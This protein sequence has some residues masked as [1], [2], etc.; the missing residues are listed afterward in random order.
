MI[1]DLRNW[2]KKYLNSG[3]ERT[4]KAK[5]NIFGLFA[6][7]GISILISMLIVPLTINYISPFKYGIW[8]TLSSLITWLGFFDIGLGNGLKNKFT[9]TIALGN[10]KLARTYVSTTYAILALIILFVLT[11]ALVVCFQVNWSKILNAPPEINSELRQVSIII[12][13]NFC[14]QLVLKIVNTLLTAIQKPALA[15]VF[16]TIS[17]IIVA[18]IIYLLIRFTDGSLFYLSLAISVTP[19]II[20]FLGS[21]WVFSH[22]LKDYRPS[23]QYVKFK[24]GK[25][26]LSLGVGFFL[27]QVVSIVCYSTNNIIITQ[28]LG[29][30]EVTVYNI[31]YKYFMVINMVFMIILIPFWSAFTE[32]STL[33]DIEWMK[34]MTKKLRIIFFLISIAGILMI[35]ASPV[36][37]KLWI[38]PSV[39]IPVVVSVLMC[40]YHLTNTWGTLHSQLM[41]GIGKIRMQLIGSIISG[42]INIPLT[43]FL[44]KWM[45]LPGILV[46]NIIV[47]SIFGLWVGPVQLNKIFNKRA[48]GIW[49]R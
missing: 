6:L 44:C 20:L 34:S 10:K 29:P 40:I 12:L 2:Y 11:T 35:V 1:F 8:L 23:F 43:I 37:Y 7:K 46:S 39:T 38:G 22:N 49:N 15:S 26:V 41:Y 25:S 31:A 30:T 42:L 45:E 9:E 21:F 24:Y 33:C 13:I 14:F 17:Q 28:M 3:H 48:N 4:I 36:V 27:L 18:I 16:D 47:F 19:T 5:K 32:A